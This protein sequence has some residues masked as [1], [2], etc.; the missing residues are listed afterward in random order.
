M[1]RQA[2]SSGTVFK[3][4]SDSAYDSKEISFLDNRDI[5]PTIRS[6]AIRFQDQGDATQEGGQSYHRFLIIT[7]GLPALAMENAELS[8]R[9]FLP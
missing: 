2:A 1:V 7:N 3:V 6:G 9:S 4:L 5:M 8:S